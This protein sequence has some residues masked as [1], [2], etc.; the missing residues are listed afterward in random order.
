MCTA[1]GYQ[2]KDFY[3]GRNLDLESSYGEQVT[4]T[5]RNLPLPFRRAKPLEHHHAM[6]GMAHAVGG[7]PLYFEATNE[8]GLSMAGLNFPKN[9]CYGEEIPGKDNISPFE[10]IPWILGQCKTLAQARILLDRLVLVNIPFSPQLPLS[11][12]HWIV[13]DQTGAVTV[14]STREGLRIYENP[15]G[16]LTN[17]PPF[18]FHLSYLS[19]FSAASAAPRTGNFPESWGIADYSRG[20]GSLSLPGD[21]SSASRFVRAAFVKANAPTYATEEEAVCHFFHMLEAVEVPRGC[22]FLESGM[23][24]YTIYSSC[25]NASRGIYYYKTYG[26]SRVTGVD[27]HRENLDGQELIRYPR[28]TN[29]DIQLQGRN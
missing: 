23:D 24:E 28:L 27:M 17:N 20:M 6:I 11:P 22:M 29:L 8:W 18:P 9:A 5:P 2:G 4:I 12:L 14:E 19:H 21:W 25:C 1:I 15:M 26:R 3:F 16:I 10:F 7:Y 13:A